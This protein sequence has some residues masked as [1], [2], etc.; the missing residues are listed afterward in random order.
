MCGFAWMGQ[1]QGIYYGPLAISLWHLYCGVNQLL[2]GLQFRQWSVRIGGQLPPQEPWPRAFYLPTTNAHSAGPHTITFHFQLCQQNPNNSPCLRPQE[3]GP[4]VVSGGP[5]SHI[6]LIKSSSIFRRSCC[7]Y[8][9]APNLCSQPLAHMWRFLLCFCF[10][11]CIISLLL[12]LCPDSWKPSQQNT[13]LYRLIFRFG[14]FWPS[15]MLFFRQLIYIPFSPWKSFTYLKFFERQNFFCHTITFC[16]A[17]AL[18]S[19]VFYFYF[20]SLF[21]S[22][23]EYDCFFVHKRAA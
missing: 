2:L 17:S 15:W 4:K 6:G 5:L 19:W 20:M 11:L 1:C 3:R 14:I 13:R 21:G 9:F 8:C 23:L 12:P 22:F 10:C 16:V 7:C 18:G